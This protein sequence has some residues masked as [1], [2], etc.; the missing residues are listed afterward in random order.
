MNAHEEKRMNTRDTI[1][2][3]VYGSLGGIAIVVLF[4]WLKL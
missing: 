3:L 2:V 4:L 1:R